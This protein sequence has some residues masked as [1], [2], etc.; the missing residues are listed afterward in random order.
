MSRNADRT[1]VVVIGGG[2]VGV[3]AAY[4]LAWAGRDVV[5]L[6]KDEVGAGSSYGNAGLAGPSHSIPLAAPGV[7]AKAL[8]W[9]LD[10]ESPFY[11][12]PRLDPQLLLWLWRFWR[13]ANPEHTRRALPILRQLGFLSIGLFEELAAKHDLD[14]QYA[15]HGRLMVYRTASGLRDGQRTAQLLRE[16]G[17]P[18]RTLDPAEL[19]DLLPHVSS[20]VTGA[21]HYTADA[22][23]NPAR[24]VEGMADVAQATGVQFR[25]QTKV[26]GLERN[27]RAICAVH[28][29]RG[30]LRPDTVVLAAGI[31]STS[32]TRDLPLALPLQP[33]K[34][35]SLT[36]ECPE[37][38][39]NLG[40]ILAESM[41]AVARMGAHLRFAG[42]LELAGMDLSINHRRVGAI[43]RAVRTYLPK[44]PETPL[45]E[46]W[47]SHRP[48][49]PDGLPYVGRPA[50]LD[51][52]VIAAGHA[53]V[54]HSLGPI[55]G[56]LV[57]QIVT[58]ETP[59]V[60]LALLRP[61]RY[62]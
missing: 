18:S 29:D 55:T 2:I 45:I 61:D 50:N 9:M 48:C 54:G 4:F 24:F 22:H 23:M 20:V 28:T 49:T 32:L 13:A 56:K 37:D 7:P 36:V 16:A 53:M 42:T 40:L 31:W 8:R 39:P 30:R 3:C 43:R 46:L 41:V 44:L 14:F 60:D 11:I 1:D 6:E 47:C 26:L 21:I 52:L 25:T 33:A 38:F 58:G 51:N 5:L 17:I 12:K 10:P 15:Q 62:G 57:A 35:Y 19:S 34:G 59:A 27:G